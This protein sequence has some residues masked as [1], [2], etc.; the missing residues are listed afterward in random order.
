MAKLPYGGVDSP[1]SP[2]MSDDGWLN[3]KTIEEF[4]YD[5]ERVPPELASWL[6]RAIKASEHDRDPEKLLQM[7]GIGHQRPRTYP[8]DAWFEWGGRVCK[9]R[10]TGE[11]AGVARD[12]V[13]LEWQSKFGPDTIVSSSQLE[14]WEKQFRQFQEAQREERIEALDELEQSEESTREPRPWRGATPIN[15]S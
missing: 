4:L 6:G 10:D 8:E 11:P 13:L 12:A 1:D 15:D 14:R 7:L 9:R 3:L 5:G 2:F